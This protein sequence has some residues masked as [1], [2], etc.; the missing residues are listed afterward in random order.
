MK[1]FLLVIPVV[2]TTACGYEPEYMRGMDL[3]GVTPAPSREF[4]GG[5]GCDLNDNPAT[6]CFER[7][8]SQ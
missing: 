2:L 6:W 7:N 8:W 3:E 1:Y 4:I 5:P